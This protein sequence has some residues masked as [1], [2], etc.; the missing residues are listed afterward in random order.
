MVLCVVGRHAVIQQSSVAASRSLTIAELTG[1]RQPLAS[2]S[3]VTGH[4]LTFGRIRSSG[5][6]SSH[7]TESMNGKVRSGPRHGRTVVQML[8]NSL[9]QKALNQEMAAGSS[10]SN[11]CEVAL[12]KTSKLFII[13]CTYTHAVKQQI[14]K[15]VLGIG[16]IMSAK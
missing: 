1:S 2:R 6:N 10:S 13:H 9:V 5:H 11:S 12:G 14:Y 15:I 8:Q 7:S 4:Q 16:I 3:N